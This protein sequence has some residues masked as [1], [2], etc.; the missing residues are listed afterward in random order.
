MVDSLRTRQ[1]DAGDPMGGEEDSI[2]AVRAA[3]AMHDMPAFVGAG[4]WTLGSSPRLSG[5]Y[6][7]PGLRIF[8]VM[9]GLEPGIHPLAPRI[10][11]D[12]KTWMAGSSP[13]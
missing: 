6:C 2:V 13:A 9:P 3:R 8:P 10:L 1:V 12:A 5:S 4:P 7:R 11:S